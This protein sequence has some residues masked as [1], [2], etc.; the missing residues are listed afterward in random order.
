ASAA[1]DEASGRA[2]AAGQSSRRAT[3]A[4]ERGASAGPCRTT[5]GPGEPAARQPAA[6]GPAD[7]PDGATSATAVGTSPEQAERRPAAGRSS[8]DAAGGAVVAGRGPADGVPAIR[9]TAE[10]NDPSRRFRRLQRR[11]AR[12]EYAG[13]GCPEVRRQ[14]VGRVARRA[15]DEDR[16]GHEGQVR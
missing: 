14:D 12:S 16:A 6:A 4:A 9:P 7:G 10:S 5:G 13:A 8:R 11:P 3:V 15:A 1:S 2:A